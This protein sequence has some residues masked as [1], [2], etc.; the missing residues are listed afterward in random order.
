VVDLS[1]HSAEDRQFSSKKESQRNARYGGILFLVYLAV[2]AIFVVLNTFMPEIMD[3]VP[4]AGLNLAIVYGVGL[5]VLALILA[6]V[7]SWLC[8]NS[9]PHSADADNATP[10]RK[11]A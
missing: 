5:I 8:R 2:Y 9:I 4:F 7:Y 11:E 3:R 1:G 10:A 6:L